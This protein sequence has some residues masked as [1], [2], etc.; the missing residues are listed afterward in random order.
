ML[1]SLIVLILVGL[2]AGFLA[3]HLVSGHGYGLIGDI[4]AGIVGALLGNWLAGM[5]GLAASGLVTEVIV[6]FIGAAIVLAILRLVTGSRF[7]GR[8]RRFL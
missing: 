5:V 3:S 1:D 8:R 6:A 7:G 2:V 4:V